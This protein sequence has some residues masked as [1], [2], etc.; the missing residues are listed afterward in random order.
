VDVSPADPWAY[1][2]VCVMLALVTT[3]AAWIPAH[4]AARID[5]VRSLRFE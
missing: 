2:S 5:P 3:A 1:V 4:R